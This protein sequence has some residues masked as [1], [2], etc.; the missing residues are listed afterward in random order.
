[1]PEFTMGDASPLRSITINFMTEA[2]VR[3]FSEATGIPLTDRS[4]TAWYP[5][6]QR[7]NGT[8]EY[9][10][11]SPLQDC[12]YPVCIPSKGRWEN[13]KTGKALDRMGV[14]Y[15][16]FVEETEYEDY[17]KAIGAEKV[18]KLP[19]HDLGQGSIPAR[20]FIWEWAKE[21]E[22]RRHWTVD[23]NITS[24]KRCTMNRRIQVYGGAFFRAI[25]DFVDR[26]ENIAMAGPHCDSFVND[27]SNTITPYLMMPD[28]AKRRV[29]LLRQERGA[30]G[31]VQHVDKMTP[32][33]I[34]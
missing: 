19:F 13:Q 17:C 7:M 31:L 14:S 1:M 25:E 18:V 20:N 24:F 22:Y 23:D 11:D 32:A 10:Y 2:D 4:D 30:G 6:Q 28:Q 5:P 29:F 12:H 26:Y 34:H 16:F 21:R 33:H 8:V 3:A 9:Y 15:R 27:R